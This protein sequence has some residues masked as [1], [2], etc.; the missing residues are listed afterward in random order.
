MLSLPTRDTMVYRLLRRPRRR[1]EGGGGRG[2]LPVT[3]LS[4]KGN[5][6]TDL[7]HSYSRLSKS[8]QAGAPRLTQGLLEDTATARPC[9]H[10]KFKETK[11]GTPY[12]YVGPNDGGK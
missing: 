6:L 5:E 2:G 11:R 8:L 3:G 10:R 9:D 7:V 4:Q 12:G 1:E